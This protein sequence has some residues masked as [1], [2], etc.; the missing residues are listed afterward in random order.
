MANKSILPELLTSRPEGMNM[1]E[2]K[3]QLKNQK[4]MLKFYK[5]HGRSETVRRLRNMK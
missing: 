5:K 2:Y 1:D 4:A 3:A